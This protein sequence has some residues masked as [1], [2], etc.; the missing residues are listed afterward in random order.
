MATFSYFR[1][2]AAG[3]GEPSVEPDDPSILDPLRK[4]DE[5]EG[6]RP[7]DEHPDDSEVPAPDEPTPLSDDLR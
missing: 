1:N 7:E 6:E 3:S 4:P 5:Y 2:Q